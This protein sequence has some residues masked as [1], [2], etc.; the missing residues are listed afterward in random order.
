MKKAL[1]TFVLLFAVT[2][3][4]LA[5]VTVRY[6]NKDSQ[7]HTFKVKIEGRTSEIK[8]NSSTTGSTTVQGNSTECIIITSCGEVKVKAGDTIEIKNGCITVK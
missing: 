8:F 5:A 7:N 3:S 4:T 6:H 1:F 2:L